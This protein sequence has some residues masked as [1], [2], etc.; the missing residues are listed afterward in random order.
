MTTWANVETGEIVEGDC[1]QCAAT[2]E[3]TEA[4]LAAM[5]RER[6]SD[7]IARAKA[8]KAVERDQVTRRDGATWQRIRE[9]WQAAFPELKPTSLGIK[10]ARATKVFLRLEAGATELD[11]LHA[12]DAAKRW[13][14]VVYGKRTK[15]GSKSDLAIDLEDIVAIKRDREFDFLVTEGRGLNDL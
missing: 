2:R 14:Y 4:Q 6:R 7:R 1:P 13:R 8:E 9:H 3:E 15:T 10:S 12:I 11:V 5:E